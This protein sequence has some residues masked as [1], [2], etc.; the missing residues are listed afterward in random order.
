MAPDPNKT[1]VSNRK[2]LRDFEVLERIEA[3]LSLHGTE[4][5]SIRAGRVNLQEAYA[6]FRKGE[7][8]LYGMHVASWAGAGPW[9][10]EPLRPRKLLL[11]KEETRKFGRSAASKGLTLVPLRLYIKDHHAKV[12]L[13]LAKGRRE[14]DKRRVV[15]KRDADREMARA[16]RS[17]G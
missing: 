2:A 15:A 17:R 12:E 9:D 7:L 16:L 1:I 10:H 13:A 4:I 3:G 14:Y 8:W 5:K 11:H 6:V